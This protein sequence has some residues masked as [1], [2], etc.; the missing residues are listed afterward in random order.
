MKLKGSWIFRSDTQCLDTSIHRGGSNPR[1]VVPEKAV[2]DLMHMLANHH[3][4]DTPQMEV[5]QG[6]TLRGTLV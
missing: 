3:G 2:L 4:G 1:R 6:L 5:V